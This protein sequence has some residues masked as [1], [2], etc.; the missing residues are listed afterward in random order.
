MMRR[1]DPDVTRVLDHTESDNHRTESLPAE[2]LEKQ[3]RSVLKNAVDAHLTD[4][5]VYKSL[6]NLNA[7]IGTE[8][9]NRVLYELIQNAH[10]AHQPGDKGRIAVKLVIQSEADGILYV[11]NEGNGFQPKDVKAIEN[12]ATTAKEVGE[13]IGNKGLGFRSIDALTDDVRIFSRRGRK[14]TK[15]FDGYCF[16]FARERE[17][18][19]ILRSYGYDAG[20]SKEVAKTV[21][22]YLVPQPLYE[23]PEDVI[24]YARRGYATVIVVPMN[25]AEAVDL[26]KFQVK[27]L[28]D[29]DVPLLLFLD[30]INEFRIDIEIPGRSPYRRRLSR[31]QTAMGDTSDLADCRMHEVRV[32][33]DRRFLVVR[34]E[35]DKER[36][37]N[38]VKRSI[39]RARSIE[40]WLGWKGQPSVSVAVGLS[41][42]A[43]TK[44]RFY[45]F[46]PMGKEAVSPLMGY[47]D[48]P[49]FADIDRRDADFDLPLNETLMKAAAEACVAAALS[50]VKHDK[51]VSQTAVFDLVAWVDKHAKK[52]DD[53]L[54]EV[55]SSMQEAP[56]IPTIPVERKKGWA[57]LSEVSTWPDSTFS[58]LKAGEV[59]KRVGAQLVS[60][61][62]DGPRL[63]RLGKIAR[64]E[65]VSL[66]PSSE[67]L[68]IWSECFARSLLD[69]QAKPKTWS[70]FYEDLNRLFAALDDDLKALSGKKIFLDRS[71]KLRQAGGHD[72]TSRA[73]VFVRSG[74]SKGKR[75]KDGVPTPPATLT[76]RYR[77]FD[78]KITFRQET[79]NEFIKAD[80]I[81]QYDP[82]EALAGL[83]SALGKKANE[84]RRREALAWAF[85]V[86]RAGGPNIEQVLQSAEL[87]VPT[88]TG[89]QPATQAA[90]SSSWTPM[91]RKL[92]NFLVETM[93]VS[94]DCRQAW[95]LLLVN[96]NS[97]QVSTGDT[98]RQWVEFLALI[99]V[100]DGLRP[101]AAR[102]QN[103][104]EGWS[105]NDLLHAGKAE[106]GLDGN[107]C[108]ETSSTSF[109]YPYTEYSREGEAWRLPGQI[110]HETLSDIAKETFSELA[111]RHLETHEDEFLTLK[112]GRFNRGERY[113]DDRI[114]PTPLATF[115]RSEAW[116]AADTQEEPGFRK[117]SEC[118]AA[119]T[120]QG[121]PPRFLDRLSNTG[122]DLVE[123]NEE[124]ANLVFGN[125]LGLRDWQSKDTAV[126][127][128]G[129]LASVSG[130]LA[131]HDRPIFRREYQRA[132]LDV[133]TTDVSLP[134]DLS[135][136][137]DRSG[138]LES[139]RGDSAA[140]IV[141][142]TQN[143]QRFEAKVL[144][145]TGRA[146]LEVGETST[147]KV[148]ELLAA[149]G[150]F[151]PCQLDGIGVRLL[152]DGERFDP[153]ASDP[154][155]TSFGLSW[156]PEVVVLGHQLLGEQL[157]RGVLRASVD[158]RIRA[159][160][161]RR[162]K[163][164]TLVVDEEK[165]SSNESMTVYAFKHEELPTLIL[166]DRLQLNWETLATEL[167]G[168]IS[169]LIDTRLR[170]LETLLLRLALGQVA[171][172]LDAPS[173]EVLGKALKCDA[174]TLKDHRAELRTDL[175]HILH[176]LMPVVAYFK[177]VA[178]ARQFESDAE[179]AGAAFDVQQWLRSQFAAEGLTPKNLVDTC[180][181]ASS[182]AALRE[183][184]GL[185]Y[186]KFNRVLLELGESPLS[187]EAGLRSLYAGYLCQ[188]R[189]EII[190]RLRRRYAA[191]FR[192]RLD[193]TIYVELKTL[194]FLKFDPQWI[195][196]RAT[197]ENAVVEE[198]VSRLLDEILGE[199]NKEVS[200]PTL[201]R[202]IE[203]NRKSIREFAVG[204]ISVVGAW[205]RRNQVPV[206]EPWK[207][208][209]PQTVSRYLEEAGL[210]DFEPVSGEQAPNLCRRAKCWPNGMPET[211]NSAILGL[212][213][214]EVKEEKERRKQEREQK[215]VEQR[216]IDFA[217][218]TLDTGDP[219][220]AEMFRQL[221]ENSISGDDSW[222]ERSRLR[223]KLAEFTE[224]G[225]GKHPGGK[226]ASLG[227]RR[228]RLPDEQRQAMGLA[229]EWLAFQFLQLRHKESFNETC[230]ISENRVHFCGG[231]GGDD[232]AGYDFCVKTPQCEWLYEVKSSLEDTGEF[233]LT[234]NEMH[235][236]IS[237]SK[238]GRRRYRILYVPFVFSPDR[239]FVLQL[240]NPMKEATR[241]RF[242][243]VGRG[244]I[245]FR[246]E[247]S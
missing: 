120:K 116:I 217:G 205:C 124:L 105:W 56:V 208:E 123:G 2:D 11:A 72:G 46:L 8:Y 39:P 21:P 69:R 122:I 23:H 22:R 173:D 4:I 164:I 45:N 47:L 90:F 141:I 57:S 223:P 150:M 190:E 49:F 102:V 100:E 7:V 226:T 84:N 240:P 97:L 195:Q 182:R 42:G 232:T 5:E 186:E 178:L 157:E 36:V 83:K 230:W 121:K 160:R 108:A 210:L 61:E 221:A 76:R 139:L 231:G 169:R 86:W 159:I 74:V 207:T 133:V 183:N 29:P 58:L 44:G 177:D 40:R 101:V 238:D 172:A 119:R 241:S 237:A 66:P 140:A 59:V 43:V 215:I 227:R 17:I 103:N 245:R 193:L 62:V 41:T 75:A 181:R 109:R 206:P 202:L 6:R 51:D 146:V 228:K 158:R 126:E 32:G 167:S 203:G 52:L 191:D 247:R 184:L 209:D 219:S 243:E 28:A 236:A 13:G 95:S 163:K 170:F 155:L 60:T 65:F 104:G 82:V 225:G 118:W 244:S 152:V 117:T 144:S 242:K 25:T 18:E 138:R 212:D 148:T 96:F 110:E 50:I 233:E 111:F 67:Q 64:R 93:E 154:L 197:L 10:D 78:E 142:V 130:A 107:W 180:E 143:A 114:L 201:N 229:S 98:K 48:A 38:A 214:T 199:D 31:R 168:E 88:L 185:D 26:A 35:V 71:N 14:R 63:D 149:T 92:E 55:G 80:L 135:L 30:R 53:A 70:R 246:F 153:R 165:V 224:P 85:K 166:S 131:S 235:V 91:G 79:L 196:T 20:T 174:E 198:H 106:E 189:P 156:L 33:E 128:L 115:L 192:S 204:T 187:N 127:R 129:E 137:V 218:C 222:F 176:L 162:C 216:S 175:G 134:A 87:Y 211:L 220:F 188:M 145:S 136:A 99:G 147:E 94:S 161:V 34:R 239:W 77:F 234:A 68:A 200:L 19:G 16:R 171:D 15:R 1:N 125:E 113:W 132:W 112:V 151:T 24:A 89:W 54:E 12:L 37:L 81:R 27:A 3:V 179:H 73:G 9:G 194:A 213:Q